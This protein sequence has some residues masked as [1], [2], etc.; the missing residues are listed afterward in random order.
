MTTYVHDDCH[1]G[2]EICSHDWSAPIFLLLSAS[3]ERQDV[4]MMTWNHRRVNGSIAESLPE[5]K[6]NL[7]IPEVA[8]YTVNFKSK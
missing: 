1:R 3:N 5:P 7:G 8:G 2:E 4:E 6:S